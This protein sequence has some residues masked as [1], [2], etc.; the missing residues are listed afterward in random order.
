MFE[1]IICKKQMERPPNIL[2]LHKAEG[3][4][5]H[6]IC[7]SEKCWVKLGKLMAEGKR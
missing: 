5:I 3:V 1:C 4:E 6:P 2:M 7:Y